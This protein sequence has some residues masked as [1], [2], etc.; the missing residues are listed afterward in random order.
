MAIGSLIQAWRASRQYSVEALANK[1]R[2]LPETLDEIE[3]DQVDPTVTTLESIAAA[4]QIPPSW[5]FGDPR[6]L[7]LL[8]DDPDEPAPADQVDPVT[9][10]ILLASR[11]DRSLYA[12]LTALLQSGEPK[13]LRAADVSLRTLVKQSKQATV[14][15]QSRPPGHFEPPSD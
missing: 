15:W 14:P 11:T 6:M 12:Q 4:L 7:E 3:S 8:F 9:E 1:A 10:R 5:L 13:L 2:I